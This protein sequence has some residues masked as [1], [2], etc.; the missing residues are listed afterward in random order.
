MTSASSAPRTLSP[1]LAVLAGL[2]CVQGACSLRSLDYLKNGHRQDGAARDSADTDATSPNTPSPDTEIVDTLQSESVARDGAGGS[3]ATDGNGWDLGTLDVSSAGGAAGFGG[4]TARVDAAGG[5]VGSGG[6]ARPD[7]PAGTGG[8]IGTGG[9]ASAG[10]SIGSG[11]ITSAG[12]AVA[13]GGTT[14]SGGTVG[15]DGPANQDSGPDA[16]ASTGGIVGTGGIG[17]TGG[18]SGNGGTLGTGGIVG[19]GGSVGTG[20][21]VGTGG[22]GTGGATGCGT[23]KSTF[24]QTLTFGGG[25]GPLATS[26]STPPAGAQL[27]Y[28]TVG[29]AVNPTLCSAGC[30][31][32]SM[33]FANGT[34]IYSASVSA[35]EF[36]S[37]LAN[38]VGSTLTFTIAIDNPGT[39][40]P[41]QVQAYATDNASMQLSWSAGTSVYGSALTA[42]AAENTP[43][44]AGKAI[45]TTLVDHT[46]RPATYCASATYSVGLQLQNMAAIT[47]ANAGLV[48]VYITRVTITPP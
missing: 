5:A 4:A 27:T 35:V 28:T 14:S 2:V 36:F 46:G 30:A 1:I 43:A 29:P 45:S 23:A 44:G 19:T 38:L 33:N 12:G 10:G 15:A 6:S 17:S 18:T 24:T 48:T 31:A 34:A 32:L 25:L 26:P 3:N 7:G 13:S 20:G 9:N 40:V 42:Y 41:I 37:P 21:T 8:F 11:G 22:A 16:P 47:S 39:R